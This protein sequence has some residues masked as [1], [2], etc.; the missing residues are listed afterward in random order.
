LSGWEAKVVKEDGSLAGY[1]EP[2][3]LVL[4]GPAVALRYEGNPEE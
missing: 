3:E 4:R 2:G 1:N